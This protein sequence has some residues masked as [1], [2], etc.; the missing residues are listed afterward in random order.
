MAS[1]FLRLTDEQIRAAESR[2][3]EISESRGRMTPDARYMRDARYHALVNWMELQIEAANLTPT[4]L[5]E[6]V[7]LAA[8]HYETRRLRS[9]IQGD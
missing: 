4:E 3:A 9:A 5:R 1:E 7:I 6:A 8:V 2:L